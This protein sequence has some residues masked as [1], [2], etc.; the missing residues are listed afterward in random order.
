[1]FQWLAKATRRLSQASGE[2]SEPSSRYANIR[3]DFVRERLQRASWAERDGID[4]LLEVVA[5]VARGVHS[6]VSAWAFS[7]LRAR[8][9]AECEAIRQ[10]LD[11]GRRIT[12][13]VFDQIEADVAR[14]ARERQAERDQAD[15]AELEGKRQEWLKHGGRP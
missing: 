7:S 3:T 1:M 12:E 11:E 14:A 6:T 15:A 10:E 5:F 8:Y 4:D 2:S 13:E 9:P